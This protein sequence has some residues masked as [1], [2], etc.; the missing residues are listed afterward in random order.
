MSHVIALHVRREDKL[1]TAD[2]VT[3][4]KGTQGLCKLSWEIWI[5]IIKL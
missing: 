3:P 2:K 5:L 4:F 1:I